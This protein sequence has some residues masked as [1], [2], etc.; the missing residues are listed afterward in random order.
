MCWRTM[1]SRTQYPNTTS[2]H[3]KSKRWRDQNVHNINGEYD[4][5]VAMVAEHKDCHRIDAHSVAVTR[6]L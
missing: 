3:V 1:M 5:R 2:S 4:E 6:A